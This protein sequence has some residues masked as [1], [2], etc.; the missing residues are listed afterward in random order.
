[1]KLLCRVVQ[2]TVG[3]GVMSFSHVVDLWWWSDSSGHPALRVCILY[4]AHTPVLRT[5]SEDAGGAP[6]DVVFLLLRDRRGFLR[7]Q[8]R[9]GRGGRH[10]LAAQGRERA[11]GE[12]RDGDGEPGEVPRRGAVLLRVCNGGGEI[13]NF[14]IWQKFVSRT[15]LEFSI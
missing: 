2:A 14:A 11:E 13:R 5:Y 9:S 4:C 15:L 6:R 12:E 1:M 10:L 8:P 7:A 3:E